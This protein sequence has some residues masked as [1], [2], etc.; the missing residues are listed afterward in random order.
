MNI[1]SHHFTKYSIYKLVSVDPAAVLKSIGDDND[2]EM[3][4]AIFRPGVAGVQVALI[5]D[6]YLV[7]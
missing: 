3:T 2:F 5:F 1:G 6:E 4:A 7:R